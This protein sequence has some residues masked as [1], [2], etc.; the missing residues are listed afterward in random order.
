[1]V[2]PTEHG[3]F[4]PAENWGDPSKICGFLLMAMLVIRRET[5]WPVIIHNAYETAGHSED[6]QHYKAKATDWHFVTNTPFK[7]QVKIVI[8]ILDRYQLSDSVGLGLYPFWNNPGFHTDS[9]GRRA[10]WSYNEEGKM[11]SFEEGMI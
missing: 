10:R 11:V 7:Q 2:A 3:G 8:E 4:T 5:G 9:R 1:M 6:S